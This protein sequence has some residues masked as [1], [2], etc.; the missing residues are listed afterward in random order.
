M[1]VVSFQIECF[2]NTREAV[3]E[4]L[5]RLSLDILNL[6]GGAPWLTIDDDTTRI[7][8]HQNALKDNDDFAYKAVRKVA[9]QG[10]MVIGEG[11]GLP[12]GVERQN[13]DKDK[14]IDP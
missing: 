3:N 9:Y 12:P 10:P 4:E 7:A 6:V 2:A 14:E 8:K 11:Q 13:I 1:A 5:D